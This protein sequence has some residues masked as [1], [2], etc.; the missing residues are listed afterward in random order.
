MATN[1]DPNGGIYR[2]PYIDPAITKAPA[3]LGAF[4][5][6]TKTPAANVPG[7]IPAA[8]PANAP[9][10]APQTPAT[11]HA[12]TKVY[13][14]QGVNHEPGDQGAVTPPHS[15]NSWAIEDD[16]GVPRQRDYYRNDGMVGQGYLNNPPT[17]TP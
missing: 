10:S 3:P 6:A 17:T 5:A 11:T 9:G 16:S 8:H 7:T 4:G 15:P 2:G 13:D 1:P 12:Q 14:V